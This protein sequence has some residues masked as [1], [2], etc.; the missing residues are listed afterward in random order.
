MSVYAFIGPTISAKEVR[1]EVDAIC[2]PPVSQGD[3]YRVALK[4]P[5]AIVIIDG[6]FERVPAVWHKEI[7]WA[8][9]EGIHVFGASSMGALRAAELADFGMVGVG[10]IF[11]AYRDGILED[12][13]EV[14]VA[15]GTEET[16]HAPVSEAMANIRRTLEAAE[17]A[18]VLTASTRTQ[19]EKIGKDAFYAERSYAALF[20]IGK[21]AGLPQHELLRFKDWV[22]E[23]RVNQKKVDAIAALRLV[24]DFVASGPP[25]KVVNF[26]FEFTEWWS[27]AQRAAGE[28]PNEVEKPADGGALQLDT[29]LDELRLEGNGYSRAARGAMFRYLCLTEARKRGLSLTPE[30]LREV[31][32]A[33]RRERGL[34]TPDDLLA[35]CERNGID[36]KAFGE[37]MIEQALMRW[38][39]HTI[40]EAG[41][42][43]FADHLMVDG[44][45]ER[46]RR[47]ALHKQETLT[48]CGLANPGVEETGGSEMDIL[49]DYF[50][51]I[52]SRPIPSDIDA[53]AESAGFHDKD[54][55]RRAVLREVCYRRA[56]ATSPQ[57]SP[58]P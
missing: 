45:Y 48:S 6:Y 58:S 27:R 38:L 57:P 39:M 42:V 34:L 35:W 52:L 54:G 53:Y 33:F 1:A 28:A 5:T 24:H 18:G 19:L 51:N 21:E 32:N 13:D 40:E 3:V 36:R 16:G 55:F 11:E 14:A 49:R 4:K 31:A 44:Q 26:A 7:L 8:M 10:W 9:S 46:L 47:R 15:H 37:L 20:A 41:E 22:R 29:V 17:V 50:L 43:H 56:V 23:G 30:T 2:L 12:D 25:P